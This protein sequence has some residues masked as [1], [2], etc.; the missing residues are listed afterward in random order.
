[1]SQRII[2]L[3]AS[4]FPLA[5]MA[6]WLL[7]GASPALISVLAGV[8]LAALPFAIASSGNYDVP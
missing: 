1:M 8:G 4:G 2:M 3:A 6:S 7:P 5:W